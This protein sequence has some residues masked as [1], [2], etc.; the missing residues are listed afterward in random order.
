M[1]QE[2]CITVTTKQREENRELC[3][4]IQDEDEDQDENDDVL[5]W[6]IYS[7]WNV[8]ICAFLTTTSASSASTS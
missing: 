8:L 4:L 7:G 2:Q 3:S 1:I 5:S 6:Y